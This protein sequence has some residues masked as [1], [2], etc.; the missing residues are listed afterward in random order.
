MKLL[1][2]AVSDELTES[3]R[4]GSAYTTT[5][6]TDVMHI[7]V[8]DYQSGEYGGTVIWEQTIPLEDTEYRDIFT[9]EME[10]LWQGIK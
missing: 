4:S 7:A 6:Y 10:A 2:R 9:E 3:T 8:T 1:R 5:T